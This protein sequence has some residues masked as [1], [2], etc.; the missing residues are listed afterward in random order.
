MRRAGGPITGNPCAP[1]NPANQVTLVPSSWQTTPQ[2]G[3]L[4]G[5]RLEPNGDGTVVASLCDWS[6]IDQERR[7]AGIFPSSVKL[8]F[9]ER[10]ASWIA[11][12]GA[13]TPGPDGDELEWGDLE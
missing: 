12:C 10:S 9:A 11:R 1:I 4:Y 7:Y 6:N 13:G 5:Y 3:H 2:I 8:R